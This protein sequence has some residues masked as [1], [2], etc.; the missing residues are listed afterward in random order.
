MRGA[1]SPDE[2]KMVSPEQSETRS[3]VIDG[4]LVPFDAGEPGASPSEEAPASTADSATGEPDSSSP[5]S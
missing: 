5:D 4:G 3:R 2:N 1:D